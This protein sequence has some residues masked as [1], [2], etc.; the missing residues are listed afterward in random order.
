MMR[1]SKLVWDCERF[2]LRTKSRGLSD[3]VTAAHVVR[4]WSVKTAQ[5]PNSR[6][7][8]AEATTGSAAA[9]QYANIMIIYIILYISMTCLFYLAENFSALLHYLIPM[10]GRLVIILLF[11]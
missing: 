9:H 7:P 11:A 2:A 4:L 3:D 10:G 1:A 6:N 5:S 8:S